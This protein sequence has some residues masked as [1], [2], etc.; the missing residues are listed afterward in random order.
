MLE[1]FELVYAFT[2]LGVR[3]HEIRNLVGFVVE[4]GIVFWVLEDV[5]NCEQV[6]FNMFAQLVN[7]IHN[8][9]LLALVAP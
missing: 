2:D 5:I 1:V 8:V 4:V 7:E 6:V 3:S 9:D